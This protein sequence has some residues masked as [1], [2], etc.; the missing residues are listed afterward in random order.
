VAAFLGVA[1]A[2]VYLVWEYAGSI[3]L[4]G[5]LASGQGIEALAEVLGY[6]DDPLKA[7]EAFAAGLLGAIMAMHAEGVVHRDVKPG[8]ILLAQTE[9]G[10]EVRLVDLGGCAD[11]QSENLRQD[12]AIFDPLY[13][14]PEQYIQ[15]KGM[16]GK[17]SFE[18][19]GLA[20]SY[21]LDTFSAGLVLL[22]MGVPALHT[23]KAYAGM[24]AALNDYGG[25]N[26][27]RD[28]AGAKVHI[29][30]IGSQE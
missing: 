10:V 14:A 13:G 15:K 25:L 26:Q 21:E 4:E 23:P 17:S 18:A 16:F 20:P 5:V 9:G 30:P 7:Y 12:E 27:W 28:S 1:G 3:T 8:N 11:L 24:R 22:Q 19:T 2:D 29:C 6:E